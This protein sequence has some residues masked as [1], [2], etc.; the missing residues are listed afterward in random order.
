MQ[1]DATDRKILK[2]LQDDARMQN[3]DLARS[4]DLA[5]SATLA[6]IRKLENA[7]VLQ[8]YEA[9]VDPD[10]IEA[11]LLT[12]VFIRT[13]EAAGDTAAA[14]AMA[15]LPEVLEVHHVAGD[16]GYLV[17]IRVADTAALAKLLREKL[18]KIRNIRSI[19]TAIVLETVKESGK[20]PIA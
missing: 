15:K 4:L 18:G 5:P 10:V 12:F 19:K 14:K 1:L 13:D 8:G 17:K 3:A 6:R 11:G 20:I 7:K 16:D 9:R 2:A